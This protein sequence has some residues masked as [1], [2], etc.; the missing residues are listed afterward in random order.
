MMMIVCEG[1]D[2]SLPRARLIIV[3]FKFGQA[4]VLPLWNSALGLYGDW[5]N[6][7]RCASFLSTR[8]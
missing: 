6:L 5:Q 3:Q 8:Y 2:L 4:A 7:L 1:R